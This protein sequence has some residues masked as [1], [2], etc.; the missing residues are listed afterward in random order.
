[1]PHYHTARELI[2]VVDI[3]YMKAQNLARNLNN[4]DLTPKD[5]ERI[6]DDIKDHA[7]Q[8]ANG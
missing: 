5:I 2:Q 7:R 4:K 1:M 3:M 6:L 8:V